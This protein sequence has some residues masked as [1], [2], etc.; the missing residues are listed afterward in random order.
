MQAYLDRQALL[1][2]TDLPTDQ[3]GR[4]GAMTA[5]VTAFLT[6]L[7]RTPADAWSRSAAAD[8]HVVAKVRPGSAAPP[9]E[10]R[11]EA[12]EDRLARARLRVILDSMPMVARRVRRRIDE[13]LAL[14]DGIATVGML[15]QMRRAARLAAFALA[16]RPLLTDEE[17]ARLYRPFAT[18]IPPD[19]LAT[20]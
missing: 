18:L 5:E 7:R 12:R 14:L 11:E 3:P 6:R 4:Y 10:R 2:A 8:E 17:F 16:A 15:T 13:E 19:E 9:A 20:G 1:A